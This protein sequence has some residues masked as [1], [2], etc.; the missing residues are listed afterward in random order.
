MNEFSKRLRGLMEE[1]DVTATDVVRLSKRYDSKGISK[2]NM[3]QWLSGSCIPNSAN[4]YLLSR[5]FNVTPDYLMGK[6]G[7]SA[8]QKPLS[9]DVFQ[10]IDLFSKLNAE[11]KA[12]AL[13]RLSELTQ[14]KQ[15]ALP[16]KEK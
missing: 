10:M 6:K 12:A 7:V 3:S 8:S 5:V 11:G 16:K 2:V 1:H 9:D 4:I 13:Q 15:Y 14:L